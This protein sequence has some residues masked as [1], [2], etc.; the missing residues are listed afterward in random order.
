[1]V[2]GQARQ[3]RAVA[4]RTASST[5]E[6]NMAP[7]DNGA[8]LSPRSTLDPCINPQ[9]I[10][11]PSPRVHYDLTVD[12]QNLPTP[13]AEP[14]QASRS[15][16]DIFRETFS[17]L[18]RRSTRTA[19]FKTFEDGDEFDASYSERPGWQP[20]S[21]PGYDPNL[22]DGGHASM[23][24]LSAPCEIT[25]VDFSLDGMVKQHY[26]NEGFIAFL[27]HPKESWAKCR[28]ININGLSWDVIQ[29]VGSKKGLHKLALE[30]VMNI[31]NRTKAD[32]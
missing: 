17:P 5:S 3:K 14:R 21:E 27:E 1:M 8:E 12:T 22:P 32:W 24:T 28:W 10:E 7:P 2:V 25:V 23:P 9:P 29:A 6:S 15:E 4:S 30:D 26:D 31:R 16:G 13:R 18:R 11:I 19:T 20:G